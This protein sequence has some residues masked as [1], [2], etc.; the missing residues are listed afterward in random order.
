MEWGQGQGQCQ[1]QGQML[2]QYTEHCV[3]QRRVE[4]VI[5]EINFQAWN[6]FSFFLMGFKF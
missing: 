6:I 2:L 5:Q 4:K 1:G 3:L